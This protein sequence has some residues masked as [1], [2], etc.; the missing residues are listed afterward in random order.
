MIQQRLGANRM[1]IFNYVVQEEETTARQVH[2][3]ADRVK[4]MQ[5]RGKAAAN[6][7]RHYD[8]D[9]CCKSSSMSHLHQYVVHYRN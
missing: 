1:V 7:Q 6:L 2:G 9:Q 8:I 3:D 4:E 5:R